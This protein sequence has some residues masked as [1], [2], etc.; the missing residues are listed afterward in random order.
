MLVGFVLIV[1]CVTTLVLWTLGTSFN[2]SETTSSIGG[3]QADTFD[4]NPPSGATGPEATNRDPTPE[5]STGGDSQQ[6]S[7]GGTKR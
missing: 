3:G 6:D 7:R 4:N 1:A 5:S 2:T